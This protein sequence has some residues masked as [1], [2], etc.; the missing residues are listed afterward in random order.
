M[1]TNLSSKEFDGLLCDL[2][3]V[4]YQ[5]QGAIPG[6]VEAINSIVAAGIA[7]AY[8]TNNASRSPVTVAT[9][10]QDL[11]ITT[12]AEFVHGS[13]GVGALLIDQHLQQLADPSEHKVLVVGSDY[14]R[15]LISGLGYEVVSVATESPS[16]VI[17]GFDPGIGWE[18]LAQ[19]SYAINNGAY[20]VATN[21]DLSIPRAEGIAPGNGALV[22]AVSQATGKL[23]DA[24]AGKPEPGLFHHAATQHGLRA[25][26]VVGDRL[27][28]DILGGNRADFAT[29][30]VLTGIHSR[31]DLSQFDSQHQPD[32]LID[33]LGALSVVEGKIRL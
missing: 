29:A 23:P 4:I 13:A 6:A 31:K 14:V 12:S 16:S 15:S 26:L 7:V 11:G 33:G 32:Y 10:L 20:W 28:T 2:D 21:L 18:E 24:V 9:H 30:L 22:Q 17:Q 25:P 1:S 27:D 5:G 8:V 19:A 3:G